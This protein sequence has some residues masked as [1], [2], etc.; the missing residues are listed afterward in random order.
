MSRSKQAK[1]ITLERLRAALVTMAYIVQRHGEVYA[2]LLIKLEN[3]Y[4]EELQRESPLD[5]ARRI[6]ETHTLDGDRKAILSNQ[7]RF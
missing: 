4:E 2:P 6:L 5:R 7:S 3:A 1:P